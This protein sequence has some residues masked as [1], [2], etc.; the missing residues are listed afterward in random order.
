MQFVHFLIC[1]RKKSAGTFSEGSLWLSFCG[2]ILKG[3]SCC[4]GQHIYSRVIKMAVKMKY[5]YK[6]TAAKSWTSDISAK[7]AFICRLYKVKCIYDGIIY[8]TYLAPINIK[9]DPLKKGME[10]QSEKVACRLEILSIFFVCFLFVF[11]LIF[12]HF[13]SMIP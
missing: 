13:L 10:N 2:N 9:R 1:P 4:Y 8:F 6:D 7:V 5:E 11:C 12:T 3:Y